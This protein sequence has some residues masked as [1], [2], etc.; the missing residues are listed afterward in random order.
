MLSRLKTLNIIVL[1]EFSNHRFQRQRF[2]DKTLLNIA[3]IMP[4]SGFL[5]VKSFV[6]LLLTYSCQT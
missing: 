2:D 3:L 6:K 5:P 1:Q 4:L